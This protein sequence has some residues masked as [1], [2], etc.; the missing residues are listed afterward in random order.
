M[1]IRSVIPFVSTFIGCVLFAVGAGS[2]RAS[3]DSGW[4]S[5][6]NGKSLDG[7]VV[8]CRPGDKDKVGCWK[9]VNGM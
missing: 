1:K 7:W 6:F 3:D 8:K 4:T 5:M 2:V 9:V